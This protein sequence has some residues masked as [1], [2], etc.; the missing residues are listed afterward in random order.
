MGYTKRL[1]NRGGGNVEESA[2]QKALLGEELQFLLQIQTCEEVL[3]SIMNTVRQRGTSMHLLTVEDII[4]FIHRME[5]DFRTEL[6][7]VNL[8]QAIEARK[9]KR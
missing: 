6:L 5:L 9:Y 3:F 2:K 4:S 8:E 7:H 1:F